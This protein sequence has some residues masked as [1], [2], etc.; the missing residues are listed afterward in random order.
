MRGLLLTV[1]IGAALAL[2]ACGGGDNDNASNSTTTTQT[3]TTQGTGA[4]SENGKQSGKKK[5]GKG[6]N[7]KNGGKSSGGTKTQT[8]KA[9][10]TTQNQ[11]ATTPTTP[12]GPFETAQSVCQNILPTVVQRQ[13][14]QGKTTKKKVAKQYSMGWPAAQRK[15][16][17][18]G[19][20][21]GL[22]KRGI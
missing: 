4:T 2:G 9:P 8:T 22:K 1:V 18:K 21:S 6:H 5:S 15:Q 11:T 13:L 17:Y 3:T 20:L 7:A 12:K 16:V 10:T 14:K 19:C